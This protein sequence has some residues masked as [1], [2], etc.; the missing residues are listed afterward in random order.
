M[1]D[2]AS[3]FNTLWII[4]SLP[5]GD[6]KTGQHLY[7]T[8][9]V[10]A[11]IKHPELTVNFETPSSASD[12]L[13][14]LERIS[15]TAKQGSHPMLHFECHGCLS[16]LGTATSE[17][18]SWGDLRTPLIKINEACRLNLVVVLAACN[19]A[20][21]IKVATRLDRA[22]FWAVIGPDEE[23]TAGS[24]QEDFGAF[25]EEFFDSLSGDSA[26]AALNKSNP[27][28]KRRY[29]FLS[30][31]KLFLK[32]YAKYYQQHCIGNGKQRRI[33]DLLTQ[34]LQF[35][36]V[37]QLGISVIRKMIKQKLVEQELF[38]ENKKS[39]FF[40]IDEF[41]ENAERFGVSYAD[42]LAFP[43]LRKP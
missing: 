25:Y 43:C 15:R 24:V 42:I 30:A 7:E 14:L 38:F 23:V 12:V 17:L 9:L 32:S 1:T 10:T 37:R 27:Q 36:V 40:F 22:P 33:E 8:K 29:H 2:S 26:M 3:L 39:N 28:S 13:G 6:L 4:E 19:G 35:S 11:R 16:G 20:H 34:A 41:P 31:E 5:E 21:L 18:I